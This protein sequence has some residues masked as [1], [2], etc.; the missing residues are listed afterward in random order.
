MSLSDLAS[1]GSFVS[2]VA[3]LVSLVFLYF[4]LRQVNDQ[5]RQTEKNQQASIRQARS[6]R[7]VDI[8]LRVATEPSLCAALGKGS[9]GLDDIPEIEL[10]QYYTY[11]RAAFYDWED[12]FFQNK[13]GLLTDSGLRALATNLRNLLQQ[14]GVRAQWRIQRADFSP[15]FAHWLNTLMVEAPVASGSA[16]AG[17][18]RDA[19]AA[20]RGHAAL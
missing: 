5:V 6:T 12:A 2:G 13:D 7:A 11:W 20:E 18:W 8:T 1:L 4:Q 9:A 10:L 3:V 16:L 15:E 14:I 19:L 17:A